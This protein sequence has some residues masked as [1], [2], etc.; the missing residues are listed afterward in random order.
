MDLREIVRKSSNVAVGH[1]PVTERLNVA[2]ESRRFSTDPL[3]SFLTAVGDDSAAFFHGDL[4]RYAQ[5]FS[6][7]TLCLSRTLQHCSVVRRCEQEL[8]WHPVTV[9]HSVRQEQIARKRKLIGPYQELDYQNLI[10]HTCILLDRT[11]ALSRRFLWGNRLPSFTSFAQHKKFLKAC[12]TAIDVEFRDYADRLA[13]TTDWFEIPLKVLRDKY[14][15]HSAERHL[16]FFGWS[17]DK[18]WDLE[19][20]T[21][22]SASRDKQ[23]FLER[24]KVIRF[25]P[26]RLARDVEK[27]LSWFGEY[28][29]AAT[30]VS[31]TNASTRRADVRRSR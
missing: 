4:G 20:S 7:Y 14:L 1:E 17:T 31:P 29:C 27:F 11:I 16:A 28:G 8:R 3:A 10:I 23:K 30:G 13:S 26:R 24:V 21:I 5:A 6:W 9:K 15:M 22:I 18:Y 2:N 25:S 12:P 19:M